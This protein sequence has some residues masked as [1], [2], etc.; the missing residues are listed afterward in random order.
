MHFWRLGIIHI[1]TNTDNTIHGI[2][3]W[4]QMMPY[5]GTSLC[6]NKNLAAAETPFTVCTLLNLDNW[7]KKAEADGISCIKKCKKL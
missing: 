4:Y 7:T 3:Y 6:K 5:F 1:G 2:Q